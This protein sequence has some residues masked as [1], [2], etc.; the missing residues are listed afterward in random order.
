[1]LNKVALVIRKK[2]NYQTKW[3]ILEEEPIELLFYNDAVDQL[4]DGIH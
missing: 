2:T 3:D 1:M 4:D